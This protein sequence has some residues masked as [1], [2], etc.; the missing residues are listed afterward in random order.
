MQRHDEHGEV[1]D[2][3]PLEAGAATPL[4]HQRQYKKNNGRTLE[5]KTKEHKVLEA[6]LVD[7]D[8]DSIF[9]EWSVREPKPVGK[10]KVTVKKKAKIAYNDILEA[11]VKIKF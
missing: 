1:A 2:D 3:M 7:S 5:V 6:K 9:L 11:Q 8:K 10:G 4:T